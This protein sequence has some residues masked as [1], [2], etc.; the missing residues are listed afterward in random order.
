MKGEIKGQLNQLVNI[1]DASEE[2]L[3]EKLKHFEKISNANFALKNAESGTFNQLMPS[4]DIGTIKLTASSFPATGAIKRNWGIM[5]FSKITSG[6]EHEHAAHDMAKDDEESAPRSEV[7]FLD[8]PPSSFM[9]F[10][11]GTITGEF[12]HSVFETIDFC[13]NPVD[14]KSVISEKLDLFDLNGDGRIESVAEMLES[15][16][17]NPLKNSDFSLGDI[18]AEDRLAELEFYHPVKG[19]DAY[20]LRRIFSMNEKLSLSGFPGKVG[21]LEFAPTKGF[22]HGF[23]DLVFRKDGKYYLL[24]WKTNTLG[25]SWEDYSEENLQASMEDSFYIV[26]YHIYVAALHKY[27]STKIRDY[28]YEKDFGGVFYLYVRGVNP[29][30]PGNG[31]YFDLPDKKLIEEL[32]ALCE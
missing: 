14:W 9:A 22:M 17:K 4:D 1:K 7:S 25:A 6:A 18:S 26:Q 2:A 16:L 21:R 32:C 27:L 28:D 24:D 30:L 23:I 3:F 13:A 31:V 11:S 29:A 5:S 15:V 20:S 12:V 19:L 8:A 10:P